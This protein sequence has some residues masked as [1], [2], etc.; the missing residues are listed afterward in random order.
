MTGNSGEKVE[1][2]GGVNGQWD[3]MVPLVGTQR[4]HGN[5]VHVYMNAIIILHSR[6]VERILFSFSNSH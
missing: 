3:Y 6:I 1:H 2:V 5:C 4:N